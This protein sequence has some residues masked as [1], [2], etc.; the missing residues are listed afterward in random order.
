MD[1]AY[2]QQRCDLIPNGIVHDIRRF[3]HQLTDIGLLYG[4]FK[5]PELCSSL[6]KLKDEMREF[7]QEELPKGVNIKIFNVGSFFVIFAVIFL[8]LW[9][10]VFIVCL[11]LFQLF[12]KREHIRTRQSIKDLTSL[13]DNLIYA[14]R[15]EHDIFE[16]SDGS[17]QRILHSHSS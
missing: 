4:Q 8:N 5:D 10:A 3:K 9:A 6:E 1:V 12:M 17:K 14:I 7:A 11:N 16:T 15:R 13:C 2:I